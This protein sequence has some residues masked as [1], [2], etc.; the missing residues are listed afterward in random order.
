MGEIIEDNG[1]KARVGNSGELAL[2]CLRIM[3]DDALRAKLSARSR[4][5]VKKYDVAKLTDD[6][7]VIYKQTI[8][9][10]PRKK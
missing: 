6:L 8:A 2:Y 9:N 1:Y 7:E 10:G 4:E 3:K 5:I